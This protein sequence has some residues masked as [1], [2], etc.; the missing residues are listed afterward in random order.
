MAGSTISGRRMRRL[1]GALALAALPATAEA[2]ETDARVFAAHALAL[3]ASSV[4]GEEAAIRFLARIPGLNAAAEAPV[5]WSPFF[6]NAV[7]K[8]GRLASPRPVALYY[9]PLL[10]VAV[11]TLWRKREGGYEVASARALPGERLGDRG[12]A[13]PPRPSWI[14]SKDGPVL[15]LTAAAEKRLAVFGKAHPEEAAAPGRD[16]VTFAAA[17][18]DMRAALPR[19]SWNAVGQARR[20]N[21][22]PSWLGPALAR[23]GET[24]A[25]GNAAAIAA[26]APETDAA[27]AEVLA[28]L[29]PA[30]A[31]GLVLD[32]ELDAGAGESLLIGSLPEDGSDYVLVLCRRDG[33]GCALRRF[34]LAS[35]SG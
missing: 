18:A 30:F 31:R 4:A 19:I 23:I 14:A 8:L 20:A 13:A 3:R 24:L 10:D 34:V 7:V 5:L 35:V 6:E 11:F 12:A 16:P 28:G 25:A 33:N 26:A 22:P 9:N 17:A 29:P 15:A 1:A 21:A 2:Q 27:T 32:M